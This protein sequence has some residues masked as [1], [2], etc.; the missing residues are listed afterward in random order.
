MY[1]NVSSRTSIKLGSVVYILGMWSF[2]K[3]II[4]TTVTL[5]TRLKRI[6]IFPYFLAFYTL[7]SPIE[8]PTTVAAAI[9]TPIEII[10]RRVLKLANIIIAA[11][12]SMLI[13][14]DIKISIS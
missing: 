9:D 13:N 1:G 5:I 3:N 14:P 10:K 7:F 6:V 11:V 2:R 4:N 8:F 12:A